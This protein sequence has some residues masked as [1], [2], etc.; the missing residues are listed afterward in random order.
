MNQNI[1]KLTNDTGPTE[2]TDQPAHLHI[3]VMYSDRCSLCDLW[4]KAKNAKLPCGD[5]KDLAFMD[6]NNDADHCCT[7][8]SF[9]R[10]R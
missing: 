6:V 1:T 5:G 2:A 7:H 4:Y 9:C 10:F 8:Q 3:H